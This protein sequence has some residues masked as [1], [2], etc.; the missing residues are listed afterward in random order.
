MLFRLENT[1]ALWGLFLL[2]ILALRM[3][4]KWKKEP[5]TFSWRRFALGVGGLFFCILGLARPQIGTRNS[6]EIS[7]K[8]NLF[9]ALDVS[10]SMLAT[11]ITPSRLGFAVN[12]SQKLLEKAGDVKVALYPFTTDG[13]LMM[14]LSSDV[15]AAIDLLNSLHPSITTGQGSNLTASLQSLF[16]SIQKAE[17]LTKEKGGDWSPTS[18][19][20]IS[21]GE[22]HHP[23]DKKV[24]EQFKSHKIPIYTVVTGTPTPVQIPMENR[25]GGTTGL[26]DPS[27]RAPIMTKASPEN[28]LEI[29]RLSG[30][31][32]FEARFS[33]IHKVV[34]KIKR[35]LNLG[36]LESSFKLEKDFYPFCFLVALLFFSVE[37]FFGRWEYALKAFIFLLVF[38]QTPVFAD[39]TTEADPYLKFNEGVKHLKGSNFNKAIEA[40]VDS[41]YAAQDSTLKKKALY[42]LGNAFLASGDP[43]QA[44]IAYQQ[45]R[46]TLVP[47]KPFEDDTNR[48]ISENMVLASKKEKQ[49]QQDQQSQSKDGEGEGKKNN[50]DSKGP[51]QFKGEPL[52]EGE[53][54]K[55]YEAI[56]DEER[57]TLS[58]LRKNQNKKTSNP[59]EKPW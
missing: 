17:R 43:S 57:Q 46:D 53:K 59:D 52:S 34:E 7:A 20:F 9:I 27:S 29:A 56:A 5:Y 39:D 25:F 4:W 36:K 35:S 30:G 55:V 54:K 40:F 13:F 11:D 16:E 18:V 50:E 23:L 26:R 58:R 19:L 44:L 51:K 33:E 10:Q 28:M 14:P 1:S 12:F 6:V 31:D 8:S 45:A 15:Y 21:D 47:D 22:S 38:S 2:A 41:G 48:K 32:F 37:L 49:Q 42:N 24:L 3:L